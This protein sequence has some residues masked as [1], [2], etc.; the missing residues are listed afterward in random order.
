MEG[1]VYCFTNKSMPGLCKCGGTKREPEIRCKELFTTSLPTPCDIEFYIKVNDWRKAER[2]IHQRII[3][4]GIKRFDKRELFHCNPNEIKN[5]YD[6]F[7]GKIKIINN[8]IINNNVTIINKIYK[9]NLYIKMKYNCEKCIYSTTKKYDY[10]RHLNSQ[11]H[12]K[13]NSK[14]Y[15]CNNCDKEYNV[16]QS[17]YA[18]I[19]VCKK[20][21]EDD[22]DLKIQLILAQKDLEMHKLKIKCEEE[23][24]KLLQDILINSNKTTD[25]ALKITSKTIS[26]LK[27]ANE[28]FKD[29]PALLPLENFRIMNYD[30]DDEED[31]KKLVEDILFYYRKNALHT[32]F[33]KHI[34]SEYKKDNIK[35][36]SMHTTDTSRLNYIIKTTTDDNLSKWSQDKNGVYVCNNLI[37][38]LINYHI[39]IIQWYNKLLIDELAV[40]PTRPNPNVQKKMSYINDLLGEIES[41]QLIKDTNKF[42]APFFNLD[43]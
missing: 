22:N 39:K 19:K 23:K 10:E 17:Y 11:K 41:G 25:K 43:K 33:G 42:I 13:N 35:E 14:I 38:K 20:N 28:N 30:L 31:K 26:A 7:P 15:S 21:K 34:I 1:Y 8:T 6:K 16:R 12:A 32:L 3:E 4:K 29:A 27:Y 40:D 9:N 2:E 36:Q 24:N 18:H 5:I 37:D